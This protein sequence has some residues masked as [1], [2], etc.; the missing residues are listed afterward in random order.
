MTRP[1]AEES[2]AETA[3]IDVFEVV[4]HGTADN[5]MDLMAQGIECEFWRIADNTSP[6]SKPVD[7][8][9]QFAKVVVGIVAGCM[10][11][12]MT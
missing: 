8:N 11:L 2:G 3:V 4:G 7:P 5:A 9:R 10:R 12:W 6:P 1:G